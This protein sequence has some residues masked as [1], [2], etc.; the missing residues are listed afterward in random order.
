M[1]FAS[2]FNLRAYLIVIHRWDAHKYKKKTVSDV[3][4][5]YLFFKVDKCTDM[6][7]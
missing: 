4:Y 2:I 7:A 5:M 3:K 1:C 6:V